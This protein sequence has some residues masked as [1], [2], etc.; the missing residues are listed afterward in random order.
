VRKT[1]VENA[2]RAAIAY[3]HSEDSGMSFEEDTHA[4]DIDEHLLRPRGAVHTP[5]EKFLATLP[6]KLG[7]KPVPSARFGGV[8]G[9]LS[10]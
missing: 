8:R 6:D 5:P 1:L 9:L 4:W 2:E 3:E 7:T 10:T